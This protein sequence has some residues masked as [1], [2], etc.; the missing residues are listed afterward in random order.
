MFCMKNTK[1]W[2][3]RKYLTVYCVDYE[4][5]TSELTV[6]IVRVSKGVW[7]AFCQGEKKSVKVLQ[8]FSWP[9]TL[10]FLSPE[11]PVKLL[12]F[13]WT[14]IKSP[15]WA[16]K[17]SI[18]A[19]R[20]RKSRRRW[21]VMTTG[22]ESQMAEVLSSDISIMIRDCALWCDVLFNFSRISHSS[23]AEFDACIVMLLG[24]Y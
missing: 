10:A 8:L 1:K 7:L 5:A 21:A 15:I 12:G 13:T 3:Q 17:G 16:W 18:H 23:S 11:S 24:M 9:Q 2:V 19:R 14:L 6:Q 22:I 4:V 20:W